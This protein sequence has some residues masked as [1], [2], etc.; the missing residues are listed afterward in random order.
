MGRP[1]SQS[2][3][4]LGFGVFHRSLEGYNLTVGETDTGQDRENEKIE[5]GMNRTC[6]I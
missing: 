4:L 6:T 5:I 2:L 3:F 1:V